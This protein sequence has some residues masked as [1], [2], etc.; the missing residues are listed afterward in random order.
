MTGPST[1][2]VDR[3]AKGLWLRGMYPF[4]YASSSFQVAPAESAMVRLVFAQREAGFSDEEIAAGLTA[5][6]FKTRRG[7]LW[8]RFTL[9]NIWKNELVYQGTHCI[10]PDSGAIVP[11]PVHH[12]AIL[13]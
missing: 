10:H 6:G 11:A 13:P 3:F 2:D 5:Q 9:R 1:W 4:G 12:E 8:S 7:K